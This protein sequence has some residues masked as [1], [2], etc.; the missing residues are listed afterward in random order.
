MY[1]RFQPANLPPE[2]SMSSYKQDMAQEWK[3]PVLWGQA[4][5]SLSPLSA[6]YN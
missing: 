4:E 6:T 1:L 5:Q 3:K 2:V